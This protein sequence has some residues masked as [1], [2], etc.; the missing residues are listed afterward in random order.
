MKI[1]VPLASPPGFAAV[2]ASPW[3]SAFAKVYSQKF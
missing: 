1:K 2:K 3:L